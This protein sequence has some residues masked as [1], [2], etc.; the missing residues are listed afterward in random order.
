MS[1]LNFLF[2]TG[3]WMRC[4]CRLFLNGLHD[5]RMTVAQQQCSVTAP[6]VDQLMSIDIP[7]VRAGG[8]LNIDREWLQVTDIM[9][10]AVG[11]DRACPF[12]QSARLRKFCCKL[13]GQ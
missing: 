13:L 7:L 2:V 8:T 12:S 5:G 11:E 10:D 3:P 6:V 9:S 1:P 4:Q